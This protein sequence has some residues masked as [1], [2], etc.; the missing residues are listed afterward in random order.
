MKVHW[1]FGQRSVEWAQARAGKPTASE[2]HAILTPNF[3][4]RDG[5]MI[6]T[7]LCK[8]VAERWLGGLPASANSFDMDQGNILE[9]EARP[10]L[11]AWLDKEIPVPGLITDDLE[12]MAC[13]PDGLIDEK[14][15]VEIKCPSEHVHVG[16]LLSAALPEEYM[17]QVHAS[18]HIS[19]LNY[20]YFL[21][22]C[23]NFPP[24]LIKVERD[25]VIDDKIGEALDEFLDRLAT[26][27]L[28]LEKLNGGPLKRREYTRPKPP[29]P[30]APYD[31]IP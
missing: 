11:A 5:K 15:G 20:W 23:R 19:N 17:V 12:R 16:Y 21:S 31:V 8:K 24:S 22:H 30:E 7:Y 9:N 3:K 1:E 6:Q 4:M 18:M 10:W 27:C 29:E 25:D 28:I 13:S 14:I 26:A 2:L